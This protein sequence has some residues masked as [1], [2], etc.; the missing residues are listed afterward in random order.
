NQTQPPQTDQDF[1]ARYFRFSA[2]GTSYRKEIIGGV[3]TFL[4]MAYIMFVN[5]AILGATGMD[6]GALFTATGVSAIL[7]CLFMAF[8]ARYPVAIAP[9]M[10]LNAFFAYS[11]V[12]GMGVPWQT[13]LVGVF[14]SGVIFV[15]ITLLKL[16]EMILDAIPHDLKMA[17][18]C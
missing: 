5:P 18:A 3:T 6:Q 14:L 16:R 17:S 1:I 9:S 7:G 4:A 11:V 2:E 8:I 13:A 12:L 10:G 15:A